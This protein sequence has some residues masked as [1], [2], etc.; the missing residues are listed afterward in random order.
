M[1]KLNATACVTPASLVLLL[2]LI[3]VLSSCATGQPKDDAHRDSAIPD[4]TEPVDSATR[5]EFEAAMKLLDAG[6]YEKGIEQLKLL[7]QHAKS[8]TAPY[9]NLAIAYQKVGDLA[10]AEG[11]LKLA[12]AINPDH[13]VANN[14]IG[15]VYRRT[16]RFAEA[17]TTYEQILVKTHWCPD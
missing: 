14:E 8:N 10:A 13:P 5:A 6:N 1:Q 16:G 9:I 7:T 12:L 3:S 11:N 17:K 4:K 15:L 2:A